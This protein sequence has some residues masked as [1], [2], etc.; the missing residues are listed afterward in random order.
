MPSPNLTNLAMLCPLSQAMSRDGPRAT[1]LFIASRT[2][3]RFADVRGFQ[4]REL[5][6]GAESPIQHL[7]VV[8]WNQIDCIPGKDSPLTCLLLGRTDASFAA[9]GSEGASHR[10]SRA[11]TTATTSLLVVTHVQ[12]RW[13]AAKPLVALLTV[14]TRQRDSTRGRTC[15]FA[16]VCMCVWFDLCLSASDAR[17]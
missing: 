9:G 5:T 4:S 15:S 6:A 11:L 12:A 14:R 8:L 2:G 3:Q 10:K 13:S 17:V 16:C 7:Y 1:G